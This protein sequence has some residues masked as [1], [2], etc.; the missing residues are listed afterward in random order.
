MNWKGFAAWAAE[1]LSETSTRTA[2]VGGVTVLLGHAFTPEIASQVDAF[3][4]LVA[5]AVLVF[6][7]EQK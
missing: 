3:V 1:R 7:K 4:G 2:I 6:M 5:G